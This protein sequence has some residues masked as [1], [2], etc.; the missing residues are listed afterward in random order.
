MR[1]PK[2]IA[3]LERELS[4]LADFGEAEGLPGPA[5]TQAEAIRKVAEALRWAMGQENGLNDVVEK[6]RKIDQDRFDA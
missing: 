3:E 1:N 4:N 2:E 5:L 6:F